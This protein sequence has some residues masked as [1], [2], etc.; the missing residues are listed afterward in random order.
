MPIVRIFLRQGKTTEYRRKIAD[1]VHQAMVEAMN[2]P[3]MDRF[4]G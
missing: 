1:G 3:A 2:V 4:Q